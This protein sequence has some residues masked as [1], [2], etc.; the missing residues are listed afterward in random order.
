MLGTI[1]VATS[2][3]QRISLDSLASHCSISIRPALTLVIKWVGLIP[4]GIAKNTQGAVGYNFNNTAK[5]IQPFEKSKGKFMNSGW[6]KLVKDFN[7]NPLPSSLNARIALDRTY[8][9]TQLRNNSGLAFRLD[10]TFIKTF[11]MSR[12]YG[13]NW[14]LTK[15][16]KLDFN[17]NATAVVDEPAG[18]IDTREEKDSIRE[19]LLHLGRLNN[20]R[21]TTNLTYNIPLSKI[22][23]LDW[24]NTNARY[25]ADYSWTSSG[26]YRDSATGT[27]GP[28]P[29]GNTISNSQ[30]IQL[31]G[32]FT[33]TTLYNKVPFLKK[34]SQQGSGKTTSRPPMKPKTPGD[35][36]KPQKE[37]IG[38]AH[39]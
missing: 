14:D 2:H 19:N 16:L 39:V 21:H 13:L 38:R 35:T 25:G 20:Y 7:F 32:N 6:M 10:P 3:C 34:I 30:T 12:T 5:P 23:L 37:Q 1:S 33:F 31:N 28:N 15:S 8:A 27:I 17:S 26:L 29:F 18:R 24:I 9:E 36:T 11:N 4:I 22:P